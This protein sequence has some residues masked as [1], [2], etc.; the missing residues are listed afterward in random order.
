MPSGAATA[1]LHATAVAVDGRAAL[2]LG[3]SGA[4]KSSLAL[5]LMALGAVLVAD[6]RTVVQRDGS[7][8]VADVPD[9]L[10]GLIEARG[11]GILNATCAGPVP[12]SVVIDLDQ[13]E[14]QRLPAAH[15]HSLLDL[16]LPCLHKCDTP[17]WPAAI[18]Q[19]LKAGSAKI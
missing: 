7:H 2:I 10:R 11:V 8:I 9:T 3:A 6:D 16:T 18:M 15:G 5:Q 14:T 17:A 4:G 19:Y 13:T 12:V 1:T